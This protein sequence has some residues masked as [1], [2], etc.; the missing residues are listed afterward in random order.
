MRAGLRL[1]MAIGF[2]ALTLAPV[3]APAQDVPQDSSASSGAVGPQDL[4]NF[5]LQG[6]VI[7]PADRSPATEA[8][9]TPPSRAQSPPT[10]NGGQSIADQAAPARERAAPRPARR[11]PASAEAPPAESA[12]RRAAAADPAPAP[13][14]QVATGSAAAATLPKLDDGPVIGNAAAASAPAPASTTTLAPERMPS[15]FPWLL[16]AFALGAGGVFLLLRGR[17]RAA[18]AGAPEVDAFAPPEPAPVPAAPRAAPPPAP[19]KAP[20]PPPPGVV[21][22]PVGGVVSTRLRPWLEIGF[23]PLRCIME[24]HQ[25]IFEFELELM[26]SGNSP[27]RDV[28]VEA[29]LFNAGNHQDKELGAF[30]ADPVGAGERIAGIQPLKG[31][32]LR[33]EVVA[34]RERVQVYDVGGRKVLVPIIAFNALYRWSGGDGQTST[35]Y[36]LGI[37]TKKAKMAPFRADPGRRVFQNV[38]ARPL[39]TAVRS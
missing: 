8:P 24:D 2:A 23:Q 28:L 13:L 20:P 30:F 27:A 33:T 26:N 31:M 12:P 22:P 10:Q 19:E 9:S 17:S 11:T 4:Q 34:P 7:R 25:L 6:R 1:G 35:S 38:A 18:F 37:D 5:N 14:S 16:A 29:T 21:P 3:A 15:I 36:L 39:P 32:T